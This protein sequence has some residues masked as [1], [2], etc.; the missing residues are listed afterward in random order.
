MDRLLVLVPEH[1]S[2]E[3]HE[4]STPVLGMDSEVAIPRRIHVLAVS[5]IPNHHDLRG[6]D[7]RQNRRFQFREPSFQ[8]MRLPSMD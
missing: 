4:G 6:P 8:R 5:V 2:N 3:N 1:L 7:F